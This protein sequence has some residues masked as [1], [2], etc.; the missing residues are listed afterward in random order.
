V[1]IT[2]VGRDHP[3]PERVGRRVPDEAGERDHRLGQE[4]LVRVGRR[5]VADHDRVEQLH[6]GQDGGH[7]ERAE[8]GE[9]AH[10]RD[11]RHQDDE[12]TAD[13][14]QDPE[15]AG[16]QHLRHGDRGGLDLRDLR[17]LV[18]GEQELVVLEEALGHLHRVGDGSRGDDHGDDEH[19]RVEGDVGPA[20]EAE[21]PDDGDDRRDERDQHA[22]QAAE[23]RQQQQE[24]HDDRA[25]R[26]PTISAAWRWIQ[27]TAIGRP[28]T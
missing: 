17:V 14:D 26:V 1:K 15:G 3:L 20:G 18:D 5:H 12:Q 2:T 23:V 8:D 25:D 11:R 7:P 19:Q 16:D 13:V 6:R 22:V 21:P 24:H 28:E 10:L 4:V 9:V 27:P